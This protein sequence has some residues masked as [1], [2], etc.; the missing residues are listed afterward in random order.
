MKISTK[1]FLTLFLLV[2][3]VI[4]IYSFSDWFSKQTGYSIN[5][6]DEI[7]LVKCLN[8]RGK[9]YVRE[10]CPG[11]AEQ[12]KILGKMYESLNKLYCQEN[13]CKKLLILP[14]WEFNKNIYYG[15]K[16]VDELKKISGCD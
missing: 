8:E 14:A 7:D 11:C 4:G 12:E 16:T 3:L 9:L 10:D 5:N 2:L 13:G 15:A 6:N 1:V